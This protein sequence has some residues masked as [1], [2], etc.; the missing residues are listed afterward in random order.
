MQEYILAIDQGT[1]SSRSI[2]FDKHANLIGIDQTKISQIYKQEAWV[3]HDPM[4]IWLSQLSTLTRVLKKTNLKIEQIKAI[5]ITNQRETVV[6]WDKQTGKPVYNAIVWQDARSGELIQQMIADG[7]SDLFLNKTGLILDTYFSASKIKWILDNIPLA[8]ELLA[9]NNLACGT[10]DSWLIW[11]LTG[12]KSHI[13]DVSNASRTLLFNI[14]TNSWDPE[15]LDIFN[16]SPNILP[17]VV[18]SSGICAYTKKDLLGRELAIAAICGDQ[19]ASTFGNLCIKEGMLKITYGTGCFLLMNTAHKP[20]VSKNKLLSTI[21]WNTDLINNKNTYCLEGGIFMGTSILNWLR[22]SL[23]MIDNFGE[24]DNLL[25]QNPIISETQEESL[26]IIP[27]VLGAPYWS[28]TKGLVIG[29]NPSTTKI[30]FIKAVIA[31]IAYQVSDLVFAMEQDTKIAINAIRVDGGGAVS[32][33][34][35]QLQADLLGITI[36]RPKLLELT[37]LGVA[38][39]AGLAVSYWN[40]TTELE[41]LLHIDRI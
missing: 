17:Q 2:I 1:T 34:L 37:A 14:H 32:D 15:L 18:A 28:K 3:E 41:G 38:Y 39:L 8:Q 33:T 30:D 7:L 21:A 10:I 13:T 23:G 24:L 27:K 36:E 12:G 19:M 9:S 31:T 11:N 25:S 4:E 29:I 35:M 16:I 22:D 5:G 20:L 40:N 26:I 6:L